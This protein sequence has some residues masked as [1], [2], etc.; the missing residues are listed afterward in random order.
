[1]G[2]V[3]QNITNIMNCVT[4]EKCRIWGKIMTKGIFTALRIIAHNDVTPLKLDRSEKVTLINTLRQ[5]TFSIRNNRRL[6][7]ECAKKP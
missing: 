6:Q 3:L 4:C 1:M 7:I 2:E 5:I